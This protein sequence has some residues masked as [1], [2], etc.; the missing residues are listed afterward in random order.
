MTGHQH[1]VTHNPHP[2]K[3][4]HDT[5]RHRRDTRQL[6]TQIRQALLN[7]HT[8]ILHHTNR[9]TDRRTSA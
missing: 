9:A 4:R 8:H 2:R 6:H 3:R 5:G 7:T 1:P